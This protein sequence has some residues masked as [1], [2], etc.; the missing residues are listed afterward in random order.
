[1]LMTSNLD[2]TVK[3]TCDRLRENSRRLQNGGAEDKEVL[4]RALAD[5]GFLLATFFEAQPVTRRQCEERSARIVEEGRPQRGLT[6]PTAVTIITVIVSV[7]A[8]VMRALS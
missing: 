5:I 6:W 8:I 4:A 1:M 7:L 3:D 2:P